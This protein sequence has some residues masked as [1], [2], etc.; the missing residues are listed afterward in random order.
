MND[1]NIVVLKGRLTKPCELKYTQNQRPFVNFSVAVNESIKNS[2]TGEWESR[3][4]FFDVTLWGNYG[5]S[6]AKYL[7]KGR[8]VLVSGRLRQDRWQD[9]NGKTQSRVTVVSENLELLR[10]PKGSD[11][12]NS[13]EQPA[14]P[15]PDD[16][17]NF[18]NASPSGNPFGPPTDDDNPFQDSTPVF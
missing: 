1:T 15:L 13:Q 12:N 11:G 18:D 8:E 10:E 16:A 2:A 7:T 4:N 5:A 14:P 3:P 9:Q 17:P 6:I